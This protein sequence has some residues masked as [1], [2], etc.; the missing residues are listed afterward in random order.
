MN[1]EQAKAKKDVK[2]EQDRINSIRY[3]Q[4]CGKNEKLRVERP[5]KYKTFDIPYH[6]R[7]QGENE[8]QY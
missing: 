6:P 3:R 7:K 4:N 5:K 8:K 2:R 1:L